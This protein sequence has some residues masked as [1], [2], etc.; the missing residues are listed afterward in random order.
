MGLP[1]LRL[2]IWCCS[3]WRLPRFTPRVLRLE[4]SS[5]W[6][7]SSRRRARA[8]PCIPLCGAR[9]FLRAVVNRGTAAAR[10]TPGCNFTARG[11]ACEAL[12]Q[13]VDYEATALLSPPRR[14]ERDAHRGRPPPCARGGPT[15]AF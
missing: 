6:P 2:P 13:E 10:P 11:G 3:G 1:Q 7:S 8:L 5:L 4:D 15:H 12:S 14:R 9:T